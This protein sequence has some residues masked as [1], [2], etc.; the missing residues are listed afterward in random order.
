MDMHILLKK[1]GLVWLARALECNIVDQGNTP[2]EAERNLRRTLEGQMTI[3]RHY[4]DEPFASFQSASPEHWN[5]W[6]RVWR[7][8]QARKT[9]AVLRTPS[10]LGFVESG[11]R[12]S[13]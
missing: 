6:R 11:H 8:Q 7:S 10:S 2:E 12:V 4:G 13:M 3:D 5:Q 1:E 9:A